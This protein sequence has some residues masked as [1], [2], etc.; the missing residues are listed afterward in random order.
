MI[1]LTQL[2]FQFLLLSCFLGKKVFRTDQK[3]SNYVR[4]EC[5]AQTEELP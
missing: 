4:D 5:V 2:Q 3:E 1:T